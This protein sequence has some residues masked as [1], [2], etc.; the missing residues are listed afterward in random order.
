M[1]RLEGTTTIG[2]VLDEGVVLLADRRAT[3]GY[4]VAN[5]RAEK[6]FAIT[7]NIGVTVAGAVG[8]AQ[9]LVRWLKGELELYKLE[10]KVPLS[11]RATAVLLA[12]ILSSYRIFPF[13]V[14]LIVAGYDEKPEMYALDPLGGMTE[15]RDFVATGSGSPI[16][17]GVLEDSYSKGMP[18]E[19]GVALGL[20]AL[21]AAVERDIASGE[22]VDVATITKEGFKKWK[23]EE[24]SEIMEKYKIRRPKVLKNV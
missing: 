7:K 12:N 6:I 20:R 18:L 22:G 15:E 4:L 11:T 5:K 2:I 19:K 24:I 10:A 23:S 13:L 3:L 17:Y 21:V 8:D 16:A 14:Q 1:K 9:L